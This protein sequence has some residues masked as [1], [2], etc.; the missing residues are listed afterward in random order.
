[1]GD[2]G[3]RCRCGRF[4]KSGSGVAHEWVEKP[5]PNFF[6]TLLNTSSFKSPVPFP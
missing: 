2:P 5:M 1:M 3:R 4:D 6:M